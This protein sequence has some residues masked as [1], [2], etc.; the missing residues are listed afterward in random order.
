MTQFINAVVGKAAVF[1]SEDGGLASVTNKVQTVI[2]QN[3]DGDNRHAPRI[4]FVD[5]PA[6]NHSTPAVK[7]ALP[8]QIKTWLEIK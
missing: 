5:V 4:C 8:S 6:F 1:V 2:Y 3:V 7:D